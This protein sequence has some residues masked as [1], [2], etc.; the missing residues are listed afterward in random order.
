VQKEK[1][2][3]RDHRNRKSNCGVTNVTGHGPGIK[4]LN[5]LAEASTNGLTTYAYRYRV[6][7]LE[8]VSDSIN[9]KFLTVIGW[10]AGQ[11][12]YSLEGAAGR[13]SKFNKELVLEFN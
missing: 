12:G 3:E 4:L 9:E 1:S 13:L 8:H 10:P 5:G 2:L 7:S 6:Q 11:W